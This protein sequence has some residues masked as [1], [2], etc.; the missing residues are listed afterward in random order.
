[1]I[2]DRV[3]ARMASK[4]AASR[5]LAVFAHVGTA[6]ADCFND[7][8]AYHNVNPWILRAIVARESG[9]NPTIQARNTNGLVDVGHAGIISVHFEELAKYGVSRSDL[10]GPCKAIF[11][12]PPSH[13][14]RLADI[15]STRKGHGV[16]SYLQATRGTLILHAQQEMATA[17]I[18]A[19][20]WIRPAGTGGSDQTH[21]ACSRR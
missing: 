4:V 19:S 5:F 12:Q 1:M 21:S 10:L 17:A 6:K 9:F 2:V 15:F 3:H 11:V 13:S 20:G 8:A 18:S 16:N 7:S 14:T